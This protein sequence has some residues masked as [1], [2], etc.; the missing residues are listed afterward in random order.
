MLCGLTSSYR[1]LRRTAYQVKRRIYLR[2][3]RYFARRARNIRQ[4]GILGQKPLLIYAGAAPI[5]LVSRFGADRTAGKR[6]AQIDVV[7]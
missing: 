7:S 2:K 4:M 3:L 1:K 5:D 6:T